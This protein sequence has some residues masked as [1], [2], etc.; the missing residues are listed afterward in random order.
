MVWKNFWFFLHLTIYVYNL[1][2]TYILMKKTIQIV[3][4]V[5]VL[6]IIRVASLL[7]N[8]MAICEEVLLPTI[9]I[10]SICLMQHGIL[11]TMY[12]NNL[13]LLIRLY[14]II[15][16]LSWRNLTHTL[17]TAFSIHDNSAK[18]FL[19]IPSKKVTGNSKEWKTIQKN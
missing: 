16:I 8:A 13:L 18:Y 2:E 6:L 11:V 1:N 7:A 9:V 12:V 15:F 19:R 4:N 10:N 5:Y 17:L 3:R 14:T